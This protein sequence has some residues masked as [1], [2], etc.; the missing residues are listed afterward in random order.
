MIVIEDSLI[1]PYIIKV[2]ESSFDIWQKRI[3]KETGKDYETPLGKYFTSFEQTIRH[4]I[5]V[6]TCDDF[7]NEVVTLERFIQIYQ[8]TANQLLSIHNPLSNLK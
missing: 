6:K 3:S 1:A 7:Q 4:L 2:S 5:L 8:N